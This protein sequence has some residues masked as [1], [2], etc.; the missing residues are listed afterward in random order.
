MT[1][2]VGSTV[3]TVVLRLRCHTPRTVLRLIYF[4]AA[5]VTARSSIVPY[6]DGRIRIRTVWSPNWGRRAPTQDDLMSSVSHVTIVRPKER[7][8]AILARVVYIVCIVYGY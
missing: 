4:T 5:T 2:N 3:C 1:C 6:F 7:A 8:A